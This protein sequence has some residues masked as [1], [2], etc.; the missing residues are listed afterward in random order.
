MSRSRIIFVTI[1]LVAGSIVV[2]SI[3]GPQV[4]KL[5][6]AIP[7][8]TPIPPIQIEVAV[9]P[10]AYDWVSEQATAFNNQSSMVNGQPV[11]IR[12]SRRD[13]TDVW[14]T[15]T[16]WTPQSHPIA[17][18][19]EAAFALQYA[20]DSNP[21]IQYAVV[22]PSLATTSLVWGIYSDRAEI[23]N[24]STLDWNT[25]Q[26]ATVKGSWASLGGKTEWG[27]V[28]PAFAPPQSSTAGFIALLSAAAA[29]SKTGQITDSLVT[30]S[31]F[32]SWMQPVVEAMTASS[33]SPITLMASQGSSRI[34]FALLPESDWLLYYSQIEARQPIHFSYPA[35]TLTFDMPFAV[36]SGSETNQAER[37]AAGQFSDFLSQPSAQKRAA[38]FGLRPAQVKLG[39]AYSSLFTPAINA[40]LTL[41]DPPGTAISIPSRDSALSL[42]RWFKSIGS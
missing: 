23:L 7:T 15:G 25:A 22:A 11:Q 13:S 26:Q 6:S 35:Y 17:W 5:L 29:Y 31:G 37:S 8:S 38:A 24:T 40:G 21:A 20:A 30:D 2:A 9:N 14:Q 10:M 3:F 1:I 33:D 4:S 12:V 19:P 42:L 36:W 41:K 18:I 39:E 32:Q 34:D 16:L 28:K 27:F